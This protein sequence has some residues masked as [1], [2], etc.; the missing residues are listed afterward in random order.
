VARIVNAHIPQRGEGQKESGGSV[1]WRI[2]VGSRMTWRVHHGQARGTVGAVAFS[3]WLTLK[4][5]A[6]DMVVGLAVRC[7]GVETKEGDAA[8]QP[9]VTMVTGAMIHH[10]SLITTNS[11]LPLGSF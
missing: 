1:T 7:G 10:I 6:M 5:L 9:I 3:W 4:W 11:V 8:L 2:C